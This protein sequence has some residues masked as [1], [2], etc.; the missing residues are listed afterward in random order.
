MTNQVAIIGAG[1]AG[2]SCAQTLRRAGVSVEIFEEERYVGGRVATTC[3]GSDRFDAGTQY[4][5]AQSDEFAKYLTEIVG[6]GCADTWA[7]RQ[8][9]PGPGKTI[10]EPW[11]VG[12][13]GMSSIVRPLAE[14]MRVSLG[15]R[16][17][18]LERREKGWHLW[19]E[20]ESSAG[21]FE[22]VAIAVPAAAALPLTERIERLS[23]PMRSVLM[24][25]C[26]ALM[27]RLEQKKISD[28]DV[29]TDVSEVVRWVARD[30]T[31]PG[32]DPRGEALVIHA[33]SAW[34]LAAEQADAVEVAEELWSEVG[35]FL[36][37]PPVRPSRMTAL[38]WREGIVGKA[39]GQTHLYCPETRV[40]V[41]GDWCLGSFA[42]HAFASGRHLGQAI[43]GALA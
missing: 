25:P 13:P 8:W 35:E 24:L 20:D 26:W 18:S 17:Q 12:T 39:L 41:A 7:P 29:F 10:R 4:L 3:L 21:P 11:I 14:G 31:K 16:V 30:N 27:V 37:L 36:N 15:R 1:L 6:L 22:A 5:A 40:G 43:A 38:L 34:S 32:R 9:K 28:H 23:A 2:L 19:F 42:E 33:S